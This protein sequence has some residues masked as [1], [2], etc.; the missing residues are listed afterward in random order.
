MRQRA[1]KVLD[2]P[3][4]PAPAPFSKIDTGEGIRLALDGDGHV[5]AVME[6]VAPQIRRFALRRANKFTFGGTARAVEW[7]YVEL[8]DG[9]RIYMSA[10]GVVV[11]RADVNP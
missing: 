3:D 10:A 1:R 5:I 2:T 9:L 8:A 11:T 7:A 6:D 4:N